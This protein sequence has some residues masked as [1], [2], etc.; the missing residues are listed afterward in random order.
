MPDKQEH[1][2]ALATLEAALAAELTGT[3]TMM[4]AVAAAPHTTDL[5]P[6]VAAWISDWQDFHLTQTQNPV[7]KAALPV[8]INQVS[9]QRV[10]A[11]VWHFHRREWQQDAEK[12]H[13]LLSAREP[14]D[15][16]GTPG[17]LLVSLPPHI[18]PKRPATIAVNGVKRQVAACVATT[19]ANIRDGRVRMRPET[20]RKL[21]ED[22]ARC[23]VRDSEQKAIAKFVWYHVRDLQVSA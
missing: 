16:P 17:S 2:R 6:T 3:R 15:T 5:E 4:L 10:A 22:L 1:L 21:P 12:I 11:A 13:E 14:A 18:S 23:F 8:A 20:L 7:L 9:T 19:L